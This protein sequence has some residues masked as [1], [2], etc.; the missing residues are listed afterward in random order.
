[1]KLAEQCPK[2]EA[3]LQVST[4]F[5]HSDKVGFVDEKVFKSSHDWNKEYEQICSLNP[6]E[7]VK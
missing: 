5:A 6:A 3:F 1:M 2:F 7:I 4:L